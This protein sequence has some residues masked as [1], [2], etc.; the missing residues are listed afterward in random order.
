MFVRSVSFGAALAAVVLL[1]VACGTFSADGAP[2]AG[3][4]EGGAGEA[5][6]GSGGEGGAGA[7]GEA[8]EGSVS[9][10]PFELS[11]GHMDLRAIAA[12][13][14]DVFF[15]DQAGG[16][17]VF[18]V[19]IVGGATRVLATGGAPSSIAVNG[20]YVY[21]TDPA[22]QTVARVAITGGPTLTSP[23]F[24]PVGGFVPSIIVGVANAVVTLT[25]SN[26]NTGEIRQ[27]GSDL[28]PN[29]V[30]NG[31]TN[32]FSLTA[33]GTRFYWTEGGPGYVASGEVGMPTRKQL[34]KE[35]DAESITAD[36]AGVYWTSPSTGK[37]RGSI[38]LTT[39]ITL[40]SGEI[41]PRSIAADGT[42]VY[43]T[44]S[45]NELRRTGHQENGTSSLFAGGFMALTEMHVRAIAVTSMYVVWLTADGKVLSASSH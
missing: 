17:G 9:S 40:A 6:T 45:N 10:A 27:Y 18:A 3:S 14:T 37:I 43:W 32:P 12:T 2:T 15:I 41:E 30:T 24:T 31:L 23:P 7:D 16:G 33:I 13:E 26:S 34:Y 25:G 28:G 29:L 19:P 42:Y 36:P 22:N 11:I 38:G 21:W 39:P 1:P 20:D 4:G 5:G 8:I 35:S 44:T